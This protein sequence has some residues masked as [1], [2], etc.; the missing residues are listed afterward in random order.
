MYMTK[1][2]TISTTPSS[3]SLPLASDRK[4]NFQEN[5]EQKKWSFFTW[6][7][8][9][10]VVKVFV[11]LA[12]KKSAFTTLRQRSWAGGGEERCHD[13]NKP[14]KPSPRTGKFSFS[15]W[16][17]FLVHGFLTCYHTNTYVC[18]YVCIYMYV[19]I[20]FVCS[21]HPLGTPVCKVSVGSSYVLTCNASLQA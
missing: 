16:T 20:M 18:M 15:R 6:I 5:V 7:L 8:V 2:D 13:T 17:T 10:Q 4:W 12:E 11:K 19:C 14:S 3:T 21:V 9:P 1:K